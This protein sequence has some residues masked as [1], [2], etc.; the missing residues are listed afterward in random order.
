MSDQDKT[1]VLREKR[2]AE[3]AEVGFE[4]ANLFAPKSGRELMDL[5]NMMSTA[6]NLIAPMYRE[7]PG[8]CL[9]LI[10]MM[11]PFG[12]NPM[13]AS[14]KT[15]RTKADGPVAFEAQ[16]VMAMINASA[17]LR[18]RLRFDYEGEGQNRVCIAYGT[19]RETGDRLEYR[20]PPLGQIG[21]KNSPLWKSEPDQQL[22]YYSG[23]AFARRFFPELL[24]GIIAV[25]EAE[26]M[27]QRGPD[28]A[29][30]VTPK[31]RK[32]GVA[33]GGA[34]P[35]TE[36]APEVDEVLDAAEIGADPRDQDGLPLDVPADA[37]MPDFDPAERYAAEAKG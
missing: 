26:D 36:P 30:D 17:P 21:T 22:A 37:E 35:G 9:G 20:S 11:R 1:L 27:P 4:S 23:R 5:A 25:D 3:L 6:G 32:G 7:R 2:R 28:A 12:I 10:A 19:E 14:W 15:Y 16:L 18:G 29:R 31:P 8:D 24:M 13:L 34:L 33:W